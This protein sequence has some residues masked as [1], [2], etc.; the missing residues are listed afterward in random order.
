MAHSHASTGARLAF[1]IALTSAFV[2][3]EG[4]AGYFANSLALLSDAGHNFADVLALLLSWYAH[5]MA[6]RPADARRTFG[7]HRVGVLAALVNAVFLVVL[8]L[9]IFWEA[10]QRLASPQP[11]QPGLMI[12]VALAAVAVN[13]VVGL[14]LHKEAKHDLNVRSAYL[15]ILGDAASA[16]GVVLAGVVTALTGFAAADAVASFLIGALILAS[17]WGILREAVDV[18][19]EAAPKG[20]DV[21]ALAKALKDLP[22][23]RSIHDLHVWTVASGVAACS[24]H[25]VVPEQTVRAG[26]QVL[27]AAAELLRERFGVAHTTIQVE[28]EGCDPDDLYCRIH[29]AGHDHDGCDHEHPHGPMEAKSRP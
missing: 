5:R 17:S 24:C 11:V 15:H 23:V 22:G 3:G 18:L 10:A 19:L 8:A 28:V 29:P 9:V 14:W 16:L 6:R 2:V 13:G 12:G 7:Y 27:R 1:S 4:I 26:Q 21:N 20:L 25:L